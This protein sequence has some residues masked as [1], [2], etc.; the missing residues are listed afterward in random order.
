MKIWPIMR[1]TN[2]KIPEM[3]WILELVDKNIKIIVIT[4]F[5]IFKKVSKDW[6]HGRYLKRPKSISEEEKYNIWDEK[7]IGQA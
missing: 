5:H 7:D 1:E 6:E 3:I 2:E 4:I